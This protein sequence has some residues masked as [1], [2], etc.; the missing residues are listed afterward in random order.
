MAR[1]YFQ[2]PLETGMDAF[3]RSYDRTQAI[4]DRAT[5]ARAGRQLATGDRRGAAATFAEG[6]MIAPSRQM[7]ADQQGEEDRAL[8][9]ST[10]AQ[11]MDLEKGKR[12]V[13]VLTRLAK[14]LQGVPAGQRRQALQQ[15]M[16]IFDQLQIDKSQ[17]EGLTEDQLTDDQLELFAGE[18]EKQWQVI[19]LG[20]GGA[21]QYNNRT[22]AFKT[23]REPDPPPIVLGGGAVAI[24]RDGGGVVARNPKTFAPPRPRAPGAGMGGIKTE[25]LIAALRGR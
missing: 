14:G 24:D 13:D 8:A 3:D 2:D 11:Q 7:T 4:G 23:L 16:P 15:A 22:G 18:L 1:N 17:L 5:T 6:G 21:A 9:Q 19:N 12:T 20:N 25:E 10:Q